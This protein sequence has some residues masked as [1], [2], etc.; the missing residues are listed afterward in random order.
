MG[1][2][3][4]RAITFLMAIGGE[5]AWRWRGGKHGDVEEENVVVII[6]VIIA[7]TESDK[8]DSEDDWWCSILRGRDREGLLIAQPYGDYVDC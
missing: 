4:G 7:G 6:P 8:D 3:E 5:G 2:G 1:G